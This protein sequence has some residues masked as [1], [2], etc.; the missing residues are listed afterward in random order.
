MISMAKAFT[1]D[2]NYEYTESIMSKFVFSQSNIIRFTIYG[3]YI[4]IYPVT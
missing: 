2:V 4:V 3:Y 1:G